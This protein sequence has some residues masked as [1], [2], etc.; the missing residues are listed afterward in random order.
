MAVG[1]SEQANL[2]VIE[3]A[4][5]GIAE[6]LLWA[7]NT[8]I[9]PLPSPKKLVTSRSFRRIGEFRPHR[10]PLQQQ[11]SQLVDI[12]PYPHSAIRASKMRVIIM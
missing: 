6:A 2:P 7:D 9:A 5:I 4:I 8:R 11:E 12:L 3:S 10:R 1:V